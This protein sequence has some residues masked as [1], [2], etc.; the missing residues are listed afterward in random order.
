MP[1]IYSNEKRQEIRN[2]LML[3]GLELIK[4]NGLKRMSIQELTKRVGIAQGTF[5]N[6]FSSKEMLVYEL[7]DVYQKRTKLQLEEIIQAK[8]YLE[9]NDLGELYSRMFLRDEDNVYRFI[10]R[11]DLQNLYTRLPRDCFYRMTDIKAEMERNLLH[12]REKKENYDLNAVINWIQIMNLTLQNK[13][14]LV[15][16]GIEKMILRMIENMLDELFI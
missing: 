6:F 15:A 2:Q 11:E 3:V 7:A 13:D 12:A 14:I 10:T 4:Q 16:A 9:R 5:Y 8:G 1:K